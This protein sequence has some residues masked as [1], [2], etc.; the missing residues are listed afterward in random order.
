MTRQN[1]RKRMHSFNNTDRM[2]GSSFVARVMTL[3]NVGLNRSH[4]EVVVI[5]G[6]CQAQ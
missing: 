4:N 5:Y 2:I 3:L 6:R 1:M